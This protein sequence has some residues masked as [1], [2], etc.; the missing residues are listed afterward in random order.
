MEDIEDVINVIKQTGMLEFVDVGQDYL[1]PGTIIQTDYANGTTATEESNASTSDISANEEAVEADITSTPTSD[2][3]T[4]IED[5]TE[6]VYHTVITGA[7]L[8]TVIVTAPQTPTDGYA[9]AFKLK[10]DATEI[11]GD[12]TKNNVG[13][14]LAIVLDKEI[15]STPVIRQAIETGEGSIS[16]SERKCLYI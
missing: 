3:D 1:E 6:K 15:V 7:D 14:M 13:S 10:S 16:G 8:D 4:E 5:T 9:V 12:F 2:T 11:F